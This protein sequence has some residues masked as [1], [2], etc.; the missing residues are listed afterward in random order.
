MRL[1]TPL[2]I[3]ATCAVLAL[4][5][6]ACGS[7]SGTK[8]A[9]V[10]APGS[11]AAS[12]A[13]TSAAPSASP[14]PTG[15]DLSTMTGNQILQQATAALK[16]ASSLKLDANVTNSGSPVEM[17]MS[18]D[19]KGDCN[20]SIGMGAKGRADL[21]RTPQQTYMR[22]DATMLKDISGGNTEGAKLFNG[23]W[24][25]GVQDDADLKDMAHLC[26]LSQLTKE[27]TNSSNKATKVGT[28]TVNGQPAVKLHITSTNDS[29][30]DLWV[31]AQGTPWPLKMAGNDSSGSATMTFS[32][33][34]VPVDVT[35]PANSDTIDVSKLKATSRHAK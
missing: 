34:N 35:P 33:F 3:A 18:I 29:P 12:S 17:H 28:D 24:M 32:A 31:A 16:G 22:P 26:D 1:T 10:P 8:P 7:G 23:R 20:G 9:A 25:T 11:S 4:G 30:A 15:P 2:R 21:L 14:S 6:T 13:Q 27:L 19:T 5:V